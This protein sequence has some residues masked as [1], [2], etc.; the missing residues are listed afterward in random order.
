MVGNLSALDNCHTF[1]FWHL[2]IVTHLTICFFLADKCLL[3]RK[4]VEGKQVRDQKLNLSSTMGS[5]STW[6]SF[7]NI[8]SFVS[9]PKERAADPF[10]NYLKDKNYLSN[11]INWRWKLSDQK[12][13]LKDKN[14][15]TKK[16]SERQKLSEKKHAGCSFYYWIYW[17][18]EETFTLG[19]L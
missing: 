10:P 4:I 3:W 19:M 2:T 16:I 9:S 14:H 11:K 13:Y 17:I 12:N 18:K 8:I 1:L 15:L 5:F 6:N 7:Q